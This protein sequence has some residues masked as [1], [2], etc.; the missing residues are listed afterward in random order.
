VAQAFIRLIGVFLALTMLSTA[1]AQ[2][3]YDPN[4]AVLDK[5]IDTILGAAQT[6]MYG[7][8]Q[9]LLMAGHRDREEI[10]NGI[11]AMCGP[12]L[13]QNLVQLGENADMANQ[14]V[15]AFA[16]KALAAAAQEGR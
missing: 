5:K 2:I 4:K 9:Y 10:V 14:E 3:Q 8:A 16:Y 13:F 6:C 11:V 7:R 15:R 1:N 12:Y